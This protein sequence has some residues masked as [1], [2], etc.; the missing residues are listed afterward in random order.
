MNAMSDCLE[1]CLKHDPDILDAA[2]RL[3][4]KSGA[5]AVARAKRRSSDLRN[6]GDV[7][8]AE[9]WDEIARAIRSVEAG[10]LDR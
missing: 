4:Q 10:E 6:A 2:H 7:G 3:I 5:D 9:I 1:I 8:A